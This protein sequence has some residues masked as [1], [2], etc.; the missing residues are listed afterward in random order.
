MFPSQSFFDNLIING[1][2]MSDILKPMNLTN[3]L[4]NYNNNSIRYKD[5]KI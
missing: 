5:N 2:V 1:V 4:L 3:C